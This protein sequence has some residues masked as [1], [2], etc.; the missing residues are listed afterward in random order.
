MTEYSD[1]ST[2]QLQ[3]MLKA[4]EELAAKQLN[5]IRKLERRAE[6]LGRRLAKCEERLQVGQGDDDD[7]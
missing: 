2:A 6:S 1:L 3:R 5:K 4:A 7:K